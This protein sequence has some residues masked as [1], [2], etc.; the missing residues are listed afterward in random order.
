[1]PRSSC[2]YTNTISYTH[3][4][5]T[6][7]H[8]LCMTCCLDKFSFFNYFINHLFQAVTKIVESLSF[9]LFLKI[10]LFT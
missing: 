8:Q 6:S 10:A 1:M 7:G 9:S 5:F 2:T 4:P 3:N